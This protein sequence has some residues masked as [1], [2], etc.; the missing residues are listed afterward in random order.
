MLSALLTGGLAGC[1]EDEGGTDAA[2]TDGPDAPRDAEAQDADELDAGPRP[3][4][5]GRDAQAADLGAPDAGASADA[6]VDPNVPADMR[7][8]LDLHNAARAETNS[9]PMTW[10][11]G[12]AG[13]AAAWAAQCQWEHTP[14]NQRTFQGQPFGENLSAGSGNSW[15]PAALGQGWNDE[16][17]DYDCPANTCAPG[18]MCGHYTQVIWRNSTQVGCAIHT[19]TSGSPFG[20]GSWR[21][22]VCQY[23]PAGNFVGQ[24]PVPVGDCP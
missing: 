20:G 15:T 21:Y 13:N 23:L 1:G 9:A 7:A 19:C 16:E 24:R 12:L 18:A 5:N 10:H 17:A 3:D 4:A 11:A 8:L 14:P 6:G 22:L 2:P